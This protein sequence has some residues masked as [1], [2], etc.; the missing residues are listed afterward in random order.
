MQSRR[1]AALF[2]AVALAGGLTTVGL[3][4]DE[5]KQTK[6]DIWQDEPTEPRSSWWRRDLTE[7]TVNKILEGLRKR[8]PAKA[9]EL[10][11]LKSRDP[12]RFKAELR[13]AGQ[14]E[15]DQIVR[16]YWE[17]RRQR[18]NAE[19]IDWLKDNYPQQEQELTSLKDRDPKLYITSFERLMGE[20]GSIFE[21]ARSNPELGA[22]LK[23]DHDLKGRVGELCRRL[24]S[25]KSDAKKQEL[26]AE[27]QE[28][29]ARRYDLIVR[30]KEIACEQLLRR[31][32]DLQK[33]V[34]QSKE[35]IARY[36]DQQV[37]RE[38][39]RQRVQALTENKVKFK[40]D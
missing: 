20:Y 38:N 6:Q 22:I 2:A 15:L 24:R 21:A 36:K 10:E 25:E 14:P 34:I 3:A 30:R 39:V 27:L 18:R 23:E 26:G 19:F 9:R 32:D 7:E 12:E 5:S 13:D 4:T 37:K 11:R 1:L 17:T 28:V 8:D 31:L 29:L 40:W 16:D 35:N 33:Q